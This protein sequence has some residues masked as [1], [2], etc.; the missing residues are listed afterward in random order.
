MILTVQERGERDPYD[1]ESEIW[2]PFTV[3]TRHHARQKKKK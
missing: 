1:S 3:F 2:N